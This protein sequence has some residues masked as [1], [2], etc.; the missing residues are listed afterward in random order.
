MFD[1]K[2]FG[3]DYL[4]AEETRAF[5]IADT[6]GDTFAFL[7]RANRTLPVF[8]RH[9]LQGRIETMEMINGWTSL[10]AEQV[11]HFMADATVIIILDVA[12]KKGLNYY[13]TRLKKKLP[14]LRIS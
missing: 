6:I 10:A 5:G 13:A 1:L 8:V 3:V 2:C 9:V 12:F 7:S 11:P 14:S 4:S